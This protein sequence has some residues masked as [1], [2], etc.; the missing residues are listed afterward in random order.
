[1]RLLTL[2]LS[3]VLAS[4]L[5]ITPQAEA[6]INLDFKVGPRVTADIADISGTAI[7]AN[8]RVLSGDV[9][10]QASGAFDVYVSERDAT[11]FTVDLN[12]QYLIDLDEQWFSPYFGAGG[13]LTRVSGREGLG[14]TTDLGLNLVGGAEVDTRLI[15]PFVQAQL[16]LG[17]TF[18]RVGFTAGLLIDL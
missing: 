4:L 7:G 17:S 18:D 14:S 10:I 9:P 1:M 8:L 5:L 15:T 13:G 16:T 11:V 6:Q 12:V 3:L 2:T